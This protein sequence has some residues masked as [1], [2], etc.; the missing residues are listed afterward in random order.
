MFFK[1]TDLFRIMPTKYQMMENVQ[2]LLNEL[3]SF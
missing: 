1:I 2:F 3:I